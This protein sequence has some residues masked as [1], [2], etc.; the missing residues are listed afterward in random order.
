MKH[1]KVLVFISLELNILANSEED[2]E[3]LIAHSDKPD[4]FDYALYES[5]E[6]ASCEEVH[7]DEARFA[8]HDWVPC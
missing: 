4:L 8:T 3:E 2:V 5:V 6:I 1:Y 7:R